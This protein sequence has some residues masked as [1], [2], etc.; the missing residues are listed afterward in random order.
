MSGAAA[1]RVSRTGTRGRRGL[2]AAALAALGLLLQ[3]CAGVAAQLP[4][5]AQLDP[6]TVAGELR[7]ARGV[8]TVSTHGS[9]RPRP[10]RFLEDV[11]TSAHGQRL[12]YTYTR[13]PSVCRPLV[14]GLA[15]SGRAARTSRRT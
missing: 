15:R 2:A 9:A 13:W 7:A 1:V 4:R 12:T 14:I 5:S 6:A 3:G 10:A 11:D 8:R